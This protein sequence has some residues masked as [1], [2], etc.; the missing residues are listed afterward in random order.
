MEGDTD[1]VKANMEKVA[2][3]SEINTIR[4]VLR[5]AVDLN[6]PAPPPSHERQ[7]RKRRRKRKHHSS[8][9]PAP[10]E[11][12]VRKSVLE[13]WKHEK[14]AIA[15]IDAENERISMKDQALRWLGRCAG[16]DGC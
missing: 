11:E 15:A 16:G 7:G 9:R 13:A 8:P 3:A 12:D 14:N 10:A 6:E 2:S 4:R 5:A 1:F